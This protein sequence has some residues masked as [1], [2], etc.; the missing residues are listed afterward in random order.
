MNAIDT[1]RKQRSDADQKTSQPRE[2]QHFV[3]D[4]DFANLSVGG[5]I[6]EIFSNRHDN[7]F[8]DKAPV[9]K[10]AARG[11][12]EEALYSPNEVYAS[13]LMP[14]QMKYTAI[15]RPEQISKGTIEMWSDTYE[16]KMNLNQGA[17]VTM[18]P[19]VQ[20]SPFAVQREADARRGNA[21]WRPNDQALRERAFQM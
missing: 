15:T 9:E 7:A 14:S 19:L 13:D 18:K 1:I 5:T 2:G 3:L 12:I 11:I 17:F 6:D 20:K 21:S 8:K 16:S 4:Q 10:P